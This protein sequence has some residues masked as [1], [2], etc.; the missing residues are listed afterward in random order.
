MLQANPKI[1]K[2]TVLY[3]KDATP[4]VEDRLVVASA[5]PLFSSTMD[6]VKCIT[7]NVEDK[8]TLVVLTGNKPWVFEIR[9]ECA[10]AFFAPANTL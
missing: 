6:A 3:E 2:C 10:H 4:L 7:Q 1:A 9:K 8:K 5:S